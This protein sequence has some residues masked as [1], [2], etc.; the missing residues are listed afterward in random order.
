MISIEK[1]GKTVEDAV[2]AGLKELNKDSSDVTIDVLEF[3][4]PGLFGMFGKLA[5][6]RLTV[7]EEAELDFEMPVFSLDVTSEKKA[8]ENQREQK[9]SEPRPE[10]K[11]AEPKT[12]ARRET[13]SVAS[14]PVSVPAQREVAQ[15]SEAPREDRREASAQ[16]APRKPRPN[17]ENAAPRREDARRDPMPPASTQDLPQTDPEQLGPDG[18]TAYNFL[19]QLTHLM[20]SDV[21]IRVKEDEGHLSVQMIGDTLGILIGRRGET[22]DALQYL[23]SLEVNKDRSDYLRVTLDTEYYRARREEALQHLAERMANRVRKTGHRMALEPMNPYERRV[24]HSALQNH[25]YVTTHSEGEEP[26]RRVIIT[27]K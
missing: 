9:K 15:A 21:E 26:Y 11:K 8:K 6:V 7:K 19:K 5:K 17:R 16:R 1:S 10:P 3:G 20:N 13:A 18:K 2:Q 12:E 24:L 22:L 23:T 27:P 14:E 25:S 4:S